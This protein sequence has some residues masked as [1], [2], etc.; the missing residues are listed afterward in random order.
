MSA[1]APS[2]IS[3]NESFIPPGQRGFPGRGKNL[4]QRRGET[5]GL[6][7][8]SWTE[9]RFVQR[10]KACNRMSIKSSSISLIVDFGTNTQPYIHQKVLHPSQQKLFLGRRKETGEQPY[11]DRYVDLMKNN[12]RP[13]RAALSIYKSFI[14]LGQRRIPRP[15]ERLSGRRASEPSGGGKDWQPYAS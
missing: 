2:R 10:K 13:E 7:G 12:V 5:L 15:G 6:M 8:E 11:V 3:I 9:D 1:R 4:G 14:H